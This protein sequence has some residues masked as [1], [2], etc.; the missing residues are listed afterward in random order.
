MDMV[1]TLVIIPEAVLHRS[2]QDTDE[3]DESISHC[4]RDCPTITSL[5]DTDGGGENKGHHSRA[6][7]AQTSLQDT[8]GHGEDIRH[9]SRACPARMS[10]QD[11]NGCGKDIRHHSEPVLHRC[12]HRTQMNKARALVITPETVLHR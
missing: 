7:P 11:T 2:P 10:P 9:Q 5:Q 4:S 8:D 1:K 3:Q 12:L 6:Y